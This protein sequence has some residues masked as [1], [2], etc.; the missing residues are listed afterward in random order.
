MARSVAL[1]V[2]TSTPKINQRVYG[3]VTISSTDTNPVQVQ[4]V[5]LY[6]SA[7]QAAC[8]VTQPPLGS[9]GGAGLDGTHATGQT[10]INNGGSLVLPW[11]FVGTQP[12]VPG[13]SALAYTVNVVVTFTDGQ[14]ATGNT[15]INVSPLS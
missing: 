9:G 15:T 7:L 6:P 8:L 2:S 3:Q 12:Q 11:D 13:S 4:S 5:L 1:A 10:V 14:T